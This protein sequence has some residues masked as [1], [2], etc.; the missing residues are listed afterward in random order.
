[1]IKLPIC[2]Y[3]VGISTTDDL[4]GGR[5]FLMGVW[6]DSYYR[7]FLYFGEIDIESML[8]WFSKA[9]LA[10]PNYNACVSLKL[11]KVYFLLT[12]VILSSFS[13]IELEPLI[14]ALWNGKAGK[15]S[16]FIEA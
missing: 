5:S 2:I 13:M 6:M 4:S 7:I 8:A 3:Y 10:S 14:T 1:M 9:V 15:D 16:L 12:G 11:F